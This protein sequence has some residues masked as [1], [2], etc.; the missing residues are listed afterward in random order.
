VDIQRATETAGVPENKELR[1]WARAALSGRRND[2]E[3]TLRI[4]D[5]AEGVELNQRWRHKPGPTNVLSF[6]CEGVEEFAPGLLGDLV[7]CAPVVNREA[8]EQRKSAQTHWAHMVV[9]GTLH[10]LGFDHNNDT[11]ASVMEH[12]EIEI[13]GRLGYPDPYA[14]PQDL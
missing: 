5:E 1:K 3:L 7:I 2:A 10:L 8:A 11:E 6:A 13:M 9:H 4:V 14:P 12:I